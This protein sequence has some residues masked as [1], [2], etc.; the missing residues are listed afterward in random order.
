[1]SP[2]LHRANTIYTLS[3][4][5][6]GQFNTASYTVAGYMWSFAVAKAL[7]PDSS[8]AIQPTPQEGDNLEF[9]FNVP[10]ILDAQNTKVINYLLE[11]ILIALLLS[12]LQLILLSSSLLLLS[13][14]FSIGLIARV[15]GISRSFGG[16]MI[17]FGI[18]LGIIYPLLIAITYGYIDVS[19]NTACLAT[20]IPPAGCASSV[21]SGA[22]SSTPA[23]FASSFATVAVAPF[24]SLSG[25]WALADKLWH[26]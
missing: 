17:A 4:C 22:A 18:G 21:V 7:I 15:F 3:A 9:N 6:L 13:L 10:N 24:S 14:F 11:A 16:A 23:S 26:A 12:Q 19:A 8:F 5:D 20:I 2:R 25:L 1:M